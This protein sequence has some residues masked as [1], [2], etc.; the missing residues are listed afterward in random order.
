MSHVTNHGQ[1]G[2]EYDTKCLSF[3]QIL[4]GSSDICDNQSFY[5]E[6]PA[7][8]E[9][10]E[11]GTNEHPVA[12]SRINADTQNSSTQFDLKSDCFGQKEPIFSDTRTSQSVLEDEQPAFEEKIEAALKKPAKKRL[13][14]KACERFT[15]RVKRSGSV[16]P[17]AGVD[18]N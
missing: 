2:T 12:M 5:A 16:K 7:D 18:R 11:H 10:R 17:E 15:R 3:D 14:K 1:N 6:E 8:V 9:N 13:K 4:P